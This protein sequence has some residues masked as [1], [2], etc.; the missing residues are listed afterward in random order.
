MT[1]DAPIK[2]QPP[3]LTRNK[4]NQIQWQ[5]QSIFMA[6]LLKKILINLGFPCMVVHDEKQTIWHCISI[7]DAAIIRCNG[8]FCDFELFNGNSMNSMV[9][10]SVNIWTVVN[11]LIQAKKK[12][13]EKEL[14]K[15]E[16][17]NRPAY[18]H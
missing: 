3:K 12:H 6:T 9:T 15:L 16:A 2:E 4:C 11:R 1:R 18:D 5:S 14:Q 17:A 10:H 13:E 7:G 8:Q